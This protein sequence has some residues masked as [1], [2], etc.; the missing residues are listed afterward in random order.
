MHQ[1]KCLLK[2][3]FLT[4]IY[5]CHPQPL[6]HHGSINSALKIARGEWIQIINDH[7]LLLPKSFSQIEKIIDQSLEIDVIS[8][9]FYYINQQDEVLLKPHPLS[10]E[11]LVSKDFFNGLLTENPLH[12]VAIIYHKTIF[13]K[14]GY[15]NPEIELAGDWELWQRIA[16]IPRVRWYYLPEALACV[17]VDT[18]ARTLKEHLFVPEK[19]I[20]QIFHKGR[21]YLSLEEQKIVKKHRYFRCFTEAEELLLRGK[22]D[23]VLS[24][25]LDLVEFSNMGDRLWLEVLN[26]SGFKY[27]KE[28][29]DIM[30]MLM[31]KL[32]TTNA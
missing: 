6:G 18:T 24:L 5:V 20:W 32:E 12:S 29:Y 9:C 27:K 28:M 2:Q 3:D 10:Q 31:E 21:A 15:F 8:G 26:Q 17:R 19:Y 11:G 25:M 16:K 30:L 1:N 23:Q 14:V 7:D 22:M 4:F 13:T